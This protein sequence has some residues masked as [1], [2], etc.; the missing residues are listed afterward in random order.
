MKKNTTL[1]TAVAVALMGSALCQAQEDKREKQFNKL[2]ADKNGSLTL[3]EYTS[4]NNTPERA[5]QF[6]LRDTD[7]NGVLSLEEFS[8]PPAKK[9]TEQPAAE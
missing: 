4:I 5:E 9:G 2:D 1:I 7:K 6:T 3:Q 8:T